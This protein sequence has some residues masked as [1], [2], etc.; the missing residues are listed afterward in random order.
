MTVPIR[1]ISEAQARMIALQH[2][3]YPPDEIDRIGEVIEGGTA[4][5]RFDQARISA[6]Y[7]ECEYCWIA[8]IRPLEQRGH[9]P[10]GPVLIVWIDQRTGNVAQVG[11]I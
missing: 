5:E 1:E 3:G 2:L 8:V 9:Q 10:D 6:G 4:D 11:Q 7:F